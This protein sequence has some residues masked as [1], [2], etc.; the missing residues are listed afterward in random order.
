MRKKFSSAQI[1]FIFPCLAVLTVLEQTFRSSK[2]RVIADVD[3]S[4][5]VQITNPPRSLTT[6]HYNPRLDRPVTVVTA[7]YNIPAK[8]SNTTYAR[9]MRIFLRKIPC[10]LYIYTE[11]EYESYF[12]SLRKDHLNRTKI[13]VKPFTAL[14]MSKNMNLW[15]A[16]REMDHERLHTPELYVIWNEKVNFLAETIRDNAFDSDYFLWTDIGSF[17]DP[18]RTPE[19]ATY[20]DT[21]VANHALGTSK[22]FFLQM[23]NFTPGEM[24]L[25][26]VNGLPT[27]DFRYNDRLGGAVLGGHR[28]AV[29][30]YEK[31]YYETLSKM[32]ELGRT[33]II[34]REFS[35][36]RM[37]KNM[38]MWR[39]HK[40]MDREK[41][42]T[43]ELYALWNEK[44]NF[45]TEVVKDNVFNSD[46]F[47]WTDI[48]SFR[49]LSQVKNLSTFPDP[50][51]VTRLLGTEKI[52]F[53]QVYD[54][55]PGEREIRN[56][57]GLPRHD[58]QRDIRLGGAVFGG[59]RDAVLRYSA[60]YYRTLDKLKANG[61]FVGKDQNVMSS[62][63]VMHPELVHLVQPRPFL[64]HG[65][66]WFYG[67]YYFTKRSLLH[68]NGTS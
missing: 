57:T 2:P 56:S 27:H 61:R 43:P 38:A 10:H 23:Y 62:V 11:S 22:V 63:A 64:D 19:L 26:P 14:K 29:L 36:L 8:R 42:H 13:V 44:V 49:D 20:P 12:K 67:I 68:Y 18:R 40:N 37:A 41:H 9:W 17:R 53:L 15:M 1:L 21:E 30:R 32:V 16:Q 24:H 34:V 25:S 50:Q 52:F 31:I 46:H 45:L 48:G 4:K 54:F 7:Y 3:V 66:P 59:H 47:L 60:I 28:N 58:F 65:N 35:Q 39:L 5:S 33:K 51:A 55:H 6:T